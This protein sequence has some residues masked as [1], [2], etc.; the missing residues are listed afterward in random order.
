MTTTLPTTTNRVTAVFAD[1][2]QAEQAVSALRQAG[3]SDSNLAI[4][5]QHDGHTVSTGDGSAAVAANDG[6]GDRVGKGLAAGAGVGALF[7]LAALAIPGVGPFITA[8]FLTHALGVTGAAVASGAIVGGTS[9]AVAGAFAKAGYDE[10][11]ARYYGGAVERGHVL[12]AV[13]TTSG[14]DSAQVRQILSQYGG[15]F[16]A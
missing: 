3:V 6:D 15:S 4:V 8:G 9:G 11:E 7:G 16:N 10:S 5:A 2:A 14:A 12:V 1:R 13:D